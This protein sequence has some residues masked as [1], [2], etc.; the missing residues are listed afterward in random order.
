MIRPEGVKFISASL[1]L[2][3]I[4]YVFA[5]FLFSI[6]FFVLTALVINFFRDPERYPDSQ[7]EDDILSPADG[8]VFIIDESKPEGLDSVFKR[9]AI[10]MSP[11]DV[12]VN[13]APSSGVIKELDSRSGGFER[14]FLE[15]SEKNARLIWKISDRDGNTFVL[16]QIAGAIARRIKAFKK[17]GDEVKRGERIG[18]IYFGSRVDIYLPKNYNIKVKIGDRV[19]SGKTVLASRS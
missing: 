14:A 15:K 19:Y 9:V 6:P 8:R 11:L 12:H 18:M 2:T 17:K 10:F 13:R 4:V 16:V 1:L 3:A 7:N 5:G